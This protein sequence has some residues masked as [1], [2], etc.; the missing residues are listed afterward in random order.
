[1]IVFIVY[2]SNFLC[3]CTIIPK[4]IKNLFSLFLYLHDYTCIVQDFT[5]R[6][7]LFFATI[8][9]H[10]HNTHMFTHYFVTA[11]KAMYASPSNIYINKTSIDFYGCFILFMKDILL[12]LPASFCSPQFPNH[13]LPEV[14]PDPFPYD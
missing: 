14:F 7:H 9:L 5:W 11:N 12:T 2:Y 13:I 8:N 4:N 6:T 10:K 1:M 3:N